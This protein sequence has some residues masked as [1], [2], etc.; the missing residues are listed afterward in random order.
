MTREISIGSIKIG[1]SHPP[2]FI[3]GPCVIESEALVMDVAGRL[4][5]ITGS[6]GVKFIFKA[7]FDKANRTSTSSFRGPGMEDGLAILARVKREFGLAVT[8]DIHAPSQASAAAEVLDVIQIPAFLCRQTD[9][10]VAAASTG[11]PVNI[12]KGQF[13]APWDMQHVVEKALSTGN[14]RII[15]TERGTF[16][17]YNRLVVDMTSL[18]EM[19]KLG[20]PV[21]FDGTHSVQL[22]G[23]GNG[24]SD[25]LREYIPHLARAAAAVGVDG[26]FFEVHPDPANARCDGPNSLPLNELPPLLET[27]LAIRG[28]V[29]GR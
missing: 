15:L 23:Q 10:I 24:C 17:G 20:C 11:K 14:D 8:S 4:K 19:R 18:P 12:K 26:M 16:F 22:P 9:L 6:L 3:L 21:V 5:E 13:M 29:D 28:A 25:G 7:S 27:L 2:L 1:G